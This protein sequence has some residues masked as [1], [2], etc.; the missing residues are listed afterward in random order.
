MR[1]VWFFIFDFQF[2][3]SQRQL[4]IGEIDYSKFNSGGGEIEFEPQRSPQRMSLPLDCRLNLA[5]TFFPIENELLHTWYGEIH[6]VHIPKKKTHNSVHNILSCSC[7]NEGLI[8]GIIIVHL[9]TVETTLASIHG[10]FN[11]FLNYYH[12]I[13]STCD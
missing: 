3:T 2:L 6:N 13:F 1:E 12:P 8:K 7:K 5:H 10:I 11:N 4:N 9:F